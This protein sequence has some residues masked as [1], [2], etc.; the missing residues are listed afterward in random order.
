MSLKSGFP[1]SQQSR[2][3][4]VWR[5]IYISVILFIFEIFRVIHRFFYLV[6]FAYTYFWFFVEIVDCLLKA[7]PLPKMSRLTE[8]SQSFFLLPMVNFSINSWLYAAPIFFASILLLSDGKFFKIWKNI[9]CAPCLI[10]WSLATKGKSEKDKEDEERDKMLSRFPNRKNNENFRA[11][12]LHE[13]YDPEFENMVNPP[14][15]FEAEGPKFDEKGNPIPQP[16]WNEDFALYIDPKQAK[17]MRKYEEIEYLVRRDFIA[18]VMFG[19]CQSVFLSKTEK[20]SMCVGNKMVEVFPI[21]KR[22][23]KDKKKNK[24]FKFDLLDLISSFNFNF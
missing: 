2:T 19:I 13:N 1:D 20:V 17:N 16:K 21:S 12:L 14:H 8:I 23:F 5:M 11:E 15:G 4:V 22:D 10:V 18:C 6:D 24:L 7:Q 9:C 3:D